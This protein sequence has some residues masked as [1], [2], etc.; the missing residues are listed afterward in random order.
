MSA[1]SERG[2][3]RGWI[4]VAVVLAAGVL[5]F[6][7]GFGSGSCTD[8]GNAPGV[9]TGDSP[10]DSVARWIVVAIGGAAVVYA[11]VRAFRRR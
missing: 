3:R 6:L 10:V 8:Y 11:L 2:V 7:A 5:V 1:R 9:C 4:A